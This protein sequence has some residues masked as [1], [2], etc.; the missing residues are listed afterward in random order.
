M[1]YQ[2]LECWLKICSCSLDLGSKETGC[3]AY[4]CL[5]RRRIGSTTNPSES[6]VAAA[7]RLQRWIV[8]KI[9]SLQERN[10]RARR[11]LSEA[12]PLLEVSPDERKEAHS[13]EFRTE[14]QGLPCM[15]AADLFAGRHPPAMRGSSGGRSSGR[16][17]KSGTKARSQLSQT[18]HMDQKEMPEMWKRTACETE[19]MRLRSRLFL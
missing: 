9:E 2:R 4:R 7:R 11:A 3:L 17:T 13:P 16:E 6:Q 8:S 5:W 18:I 19:R 15:R 10:S 12:A 1:V 14:R